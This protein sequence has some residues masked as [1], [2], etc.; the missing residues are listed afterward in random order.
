MAEDLH[1]LP[2]TDVH[3]LEEYHLSPANIPTVDVKGSYV[4]LLD[5]SC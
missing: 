3:Q 2:E 1:R 4:G 5:M